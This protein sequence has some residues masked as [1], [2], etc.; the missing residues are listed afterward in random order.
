[1]FRILLASNKLPVAVDQIILSLAIHDEG[2]F[3]T[4]NSSASRL[5][6][7]IGMVTGHGG[8]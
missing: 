7:G 8:H 5:V 1:M 2:P 3:K 4:G 6:D